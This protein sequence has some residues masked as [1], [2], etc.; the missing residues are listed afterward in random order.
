MSIFKYVPC[1]VYFFQKFFLFRNLFSCGV[2]SQLFQKQKSSKIIIFTFYLKKKLIDENMFLFQQT[3]KTIKFDNLSIFK[4]YT[5]GTY[6][7]PK[8]HLFINDKM[9]IF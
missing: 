5:S 7:M 3:F 8:V 4:F 9:R 2:V 1:L 6:G